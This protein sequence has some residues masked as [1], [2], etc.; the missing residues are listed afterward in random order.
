MTELEQYINTHFEIVQPNELI[1]VSS[2]FNQITLKKGDFFLKEGKQCDKFCFIK[3]GYLRV[4]AIADENEVTQWI[5]TN[6]HFGTDFSSFFFNLPSRWT[7]QAL[8]NTELFVITKENY[9]KIGNIIP[10]WVEL[11]RT[12]LIK[13]LTMMESRIHSHLSMSAEERYRLFFENNRDLFNQVPLQYI[14]SM[15][16]MTPE[17]FSRIRKKQMM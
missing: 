8:E 17:T 5:A 12:F 3:T 13:C 10:L 7:I 11:E 15:L 16:G 2:L 1:E 6:G 9:N 4:F 14:A